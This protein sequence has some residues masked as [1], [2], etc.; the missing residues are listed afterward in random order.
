MKGIIDHQEEGLLKSKVMILS[1]NDGIYNQ[2][3]HLAS[4]DDNERFESVFYYLE[5]Q[6]L[7]QIAEWTNLLQKLHK[8]KRR[9]F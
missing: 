1:E 5:D 2:I 6:I 8:I 9:T 3:C 4:P 7:I